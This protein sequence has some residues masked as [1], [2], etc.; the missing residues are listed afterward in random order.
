MA[1][2]RVDL[3]VEGD[4]LEYDFENHSPVLELG[5]EDILVV[6]F[7]GVPEHYIPALS[8]LRDNAPFGPFLTVQ[9]EGN[10]LCCQGCSHIGEA[11]FDAWP[12]LVSPKDDAPPIKPARAFEI[13]LA[14]GVVRHVRQI[15]LTIV[16][17][18]VVV[19]APEE[20]E[21]IFSESVVEWQFHFANPDH[22]PRVPVIVFESYDGQGNPAPTGL[23]PFSALRVNAFSSFEGVRFRV[24]G[25]GNNGIQGKYGYKVG[26]IDPTRPDHIGFKRL[27]VRNLLGKLIDPLID[28]IGSPP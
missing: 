19:V 5:P 16:S 7:A 9:V 12:L 2:Y 26:V 21:Q 24:I 20:K 6:S 1:T 3:R 8:A 28:N 27:E 23:G 4:H 22:P 25:S 11:T 15:F 10:S 18:E 14:A 17:D 13:R